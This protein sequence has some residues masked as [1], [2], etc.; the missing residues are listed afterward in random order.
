MYQYMITWDKVDQEIK[1]GDR[2]ICIRDVEMYDDGGV[3]YKKGET[4]VSEKDNCI[5]NI[6]GDKDHE[7]K[8]EDEWWDYFKKIPH[9]VE[10]CE[11]CKTKRPDRDY[12]QSIQ[13]EFSVVEHPEHYNS[14]PSGIECIQ[15][16]EHHNFCIGNAIKYLWRNGLKSEEGKT[17]REKQIEDLNKAIWYI[18]REIQNLEKRP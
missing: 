12:F 14:H 9:P 16:T 18:K 6:Q 3:T 11:T 10:K 1:K 15:V 17:N 13:A 2:F 5:T 4:Y 8:I 7:W